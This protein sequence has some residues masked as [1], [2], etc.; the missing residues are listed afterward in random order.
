MLFKDQKNIF[1]PDRIN[2]EIRIKLNK[3]KKMYGFNGEDEE[4]FNRNFVKQA[5]E[6]TDKSRTIRK[7][8]Q[9][10]LQDIATKYNQKGGRWLLLRDNST[11]KDTWE[12]II[13]CLRKS[14]SSLFDSVTCSRKVRRSNQT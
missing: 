11:V 9:K 12:N 14:P 6:T 1:K 3:L 4:L 2:A 7:N 10:I 5:L 13:S 8:I